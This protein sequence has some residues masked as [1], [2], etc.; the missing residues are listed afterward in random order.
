[1]ESLQKSALARKE[2]FAVFT[3]FLMVSFGGSAANA[4]ILPENDLWK[5]DGLNKGLGITQTEFNESIDEVMEIYEPIMKA[6][7]ARVKVEKLWSDPTV[8]ARARRDGSTWVISMYGGLAR[9]PEVT[10]D[11]MQLVVCHELGHHLGGFPFYSTSA[12]GSMGWAAAEGQSDYFASQECL[13]RV[14]KEGSAESFNLDEVHPRVRSDCDRVWDVADDRELCY[15][16]AGASLSVSRLLGAIASRPV[17]PEF[18]KRDS[19]VVTRTNIAHPAA[20]CR[21]DT[22]MQGALCKAEFDPTKIPGRSNAA[23]QGS[24]DAEREMAEN[25]CTT[26]SGYEVGLRPRCWFAPRL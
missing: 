20:Q 14:W 25:S 10:R 9:R 11:G 16:M 12:T 24:L 21:L 4:T 13:R 23:G 18:D 15:R 7:G 3:A 8:N 2:Y 19:N 5:Y 1:M 17:V 22:F 6:F 26:H